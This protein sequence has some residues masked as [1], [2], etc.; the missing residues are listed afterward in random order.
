M[1]SYEEISSYF[2]Q[3]IVK[4][5]GFSKEQFTYL[6]LAYQEA[7]L[8]SSFVTKEMKIE[9]NKKDSNIKKKVLLFLDKK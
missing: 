6:P 8:R 5:L 9:K 3:D 2:E 4:G 1:K 7:L